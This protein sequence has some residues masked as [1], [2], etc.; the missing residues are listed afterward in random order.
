LDSEE[1]ILR[2]YLGLFSIIFLTYSY[3]FFSVKNFFYNDTIINI[4]KGESIS[5]ISSKFYQNQNFL[6]KKFFKFLLIF[7]NFKK[8]INFGKFKFNK[9]VNLISILDTITSKSNLDYK[10]T[11]IEGWQKYNLNEYLNKFYDKNTFIDYDR[12]LADTY[13]INSSND[14]N[15]YKEFTNNLLNNFFLR[16]QNHKVLKK[17]GKKNILIISSLVEKEANNNFDKKLIASVIFNRLEKKMKLQI[18]ATVIYS[19]T[20]GEFKYNQKLTYND[21]KI[22]HPYNT[23]VIKGLPPGMICYVGKNTIESV[24]ENIKS[25][26]LFYFYNI[27]E[28]KH[29]FSKNFEDHKYKLYEYRKQKK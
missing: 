15:R 20:N 22:K 10:T 29:I 17:Y 7:K 18:D 19:K 2:Y 8:P 1:Q 4:D 27:L 12:I 13:Y 24:L 26:Y 25:D 9:N 21:L 11:I 14:F 5:Q 6:E 28:E 3:Y 23:Y 16:H